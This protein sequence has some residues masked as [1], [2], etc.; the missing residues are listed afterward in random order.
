MLATE[1]LVKF[2]SIIN[3]LVSGMRVSIT[4]RSGLARTRLGMDSSRLNQER[5]WAL[6]FGNCLCGMA[7]VAVTHFMDRTVE[8][9]ACGYES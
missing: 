9:H 7:I 3:A 2:C 4:N 5:E 6:E 8:L 1:V